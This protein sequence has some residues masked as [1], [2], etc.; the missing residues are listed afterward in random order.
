MS[1]RFELLRKLLLIQMLPH[2]CVGHPLAQACLFVGRQDWADAIHFWTL[3]NRA[4]R[5]MAGAIPKFNPDRRLRTMDI[6]FT[7]LC[8]LARALG[9]YRLADSIFRLGPHQLATD[10]GACGYYDYRSVEAERLRERK[11]KDAERNA[12]AKA[13]ESAGYMFLDEAW[14]PPPGHAVTEEELLWISAAG[15]PLKS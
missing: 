7:P 6:I 11:R 12:A 2:A 1:T 14:V 15:G 13:L 10:L 8:S 5:R 4:K 9:L 3:P